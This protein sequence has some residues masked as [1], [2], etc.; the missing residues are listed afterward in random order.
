MAVIYPAC[1]VR[2]LVRAETD[3]E[4]VVRPRRGHPQGGRSREKVVRGL[5]RVWDADTRRRVADELK[6]QLH[7][8]YAFGSFKFLL[9][10]IQLHL[11]SLR[12]VLP[13]AEHALHLLPSMMRTKLSVQEKKLGF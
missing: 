1:V 9:D 12:S 6:L 11:G 4:L 3:H 2:R 10:L 13:G 5:R 8:A 7:F